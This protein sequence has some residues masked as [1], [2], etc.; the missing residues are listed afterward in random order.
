MSGQAL[1]AFYR[2]RVRPRLRGACCAVLLYLALK[3]NERTND[4][5]PS[6]QTMADDLDMAST[7][8][9]RSLKELAELGLVERGEN[10]G[11]RGKATHYALRF[12]EPEKPHHTRWSLAAETP[13]P[14]AR[15]STTSGGKTPPPKS[16]SACLGTGS[17]R[18]NIENMKTTRVRARGAQGRARP[19][20]KDDRLEAWQGAHSL[21]G[22]SAYSNETIATTYA[23]PLAEVIAAR[24]R[25][26]ARHAG[27]ADVGPLSASAVLDTL[28]DAS[29]T[30]TGTG[31][32][33]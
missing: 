10:V 22:D 32:K 18:Q 2:L 3:H 8:L 13:P 21:F 31:G 14:T 19:R 28:E 20:A 30:A 5:W 23:L 17:A 12:L 9:L 16:L 15:N 26:D 6:L 11:G 4:A 29:A 1:A 27:R 24:K 25:F 33:P 7:T